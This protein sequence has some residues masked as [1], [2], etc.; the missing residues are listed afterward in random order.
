MP[1]RVAHQQTP[2]PAVARERTRERSSQA[3]P[4]QH[5]WRIA[6]HTRTQLAGTIV[7]LGLIVPASA[8][9]ATIQGGPRSEH[10]RGTNNADLI[11]G[12]AGNDRILGGAGNDRLY[13]GSGN[14]FASGGG[15]A[16]WVSGDS[17]DPSEL[18]V[19]NGGA[20]S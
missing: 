2:P 8:L 1:T 17:V 3:R 14:D 13:A 4:L 19:L 16:D 11:D 18:S 7:A 15:G 20:A 12:N 6:Q 5:E 9:A 10:L